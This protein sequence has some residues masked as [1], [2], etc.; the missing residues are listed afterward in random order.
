MGRRR[1]A[2]RPV[3]DEQS[4]TT[5][6]R[7]R[8]A[9]YASWLWFH[10]KHNFVASALEVCTLVP[11]GSRTCDASDRLLPPLVVVLSAWADFFPIVQK[12]N[13]ACSGTDR[14]AANGA[15]RR[16]A[17]Q[18]TRCTLKLKPKLPPVRA[19]SARIATKSTCL[20]DVQT[21]LVL[22]RLC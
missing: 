16:L 15:A 12:S 21:S 20:Q 8:N 11:L 9:V 7:V 3:P 5:C 22:D 18:T 19:Q 4:D 2:G 13:E 17:L 10:T 6:L 14:P 1:E